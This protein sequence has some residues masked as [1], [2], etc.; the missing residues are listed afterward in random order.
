MVSAERSRQA[1]RHPGPILAVAPR[2]HKP[3]SSTRI[4]TA[5]TGQTNAPS[6]PR[7]VLTRVG[8][9]L[10]FPELSQGWRVILVVT[11][12]SGAYSLKPVLHRNHR[13]FLRKA[14]TL[15]RP[16]EHWISTSRRP[17][18]NRETRDLSLALISHFHVF[19][20]QVYSAP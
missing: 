8:S 3:F 16:S 1:H 4:R 19:S 17:F 7:Y 14:H 2:D 12:L 9:K 15:P 18:A 13:L 5:G 6:F 11:F 20:E 10:T